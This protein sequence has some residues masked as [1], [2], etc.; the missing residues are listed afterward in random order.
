MENGDLIVRAIV[1]HAR[2]PSSRGPLTTEDL[3]DL[4]LTSTNVLDLETVAQGLYKKTQELPTQ[5]FTGGNTKE[6]ADANF[7]LEVV[8]AVIAYKQTLVEK[9]KKAAQVS[10]DLQPLLAEKL[11]REAASVSQLS[12]ADLE[13]QIAALRAAG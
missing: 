11:R 5:S 13:K 1:S 6:S 10:Q 12:D 7:K 3:F 4:P 9:E 8:K 2:F